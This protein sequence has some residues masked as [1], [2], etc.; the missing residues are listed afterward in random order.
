MSQRFRSAE[1]IISELMNIILRS[2]SELSLKPSLIYSES[3]KSALIIF[4]INN[5][6]SEHLNFE[7]QFIFLY[8]HFFL[9]IEWV[10]LT[11]S[12]RKLWLFVNQIKVLNV[13]YYIEKKIYILKFWIETIIKWS[14]SQNVKEIQSFLETVEIIRQWIKN[15]TEITQSLNKLTENVLWR[16]IQS[17]QLF[18][19]ILKIKCIT[20]I[21]MHEIDWSLDIH[22]YTDMSEFV[23]ELLITQF[24]IVDD[25]AKSVKV[26]I[27]YNT[28]T[29]SV[30]ERKYI[31]YKQKLCAIIKFI[32]K[33]HYLLWNL[34][35]QVIVHTDYKLLMHFLKLN[36]YNRIYSHWAAKLRKLNI[37]LIH[38][39]EKWNIVTDK[40]SQIIFFQKDCIE[41]ETV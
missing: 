35:Q 37:K 39:K 27:V 31:I 15:F 8:N 22:I 3:D 41:N 4:Y 36:L 6:F 18:F 7:I 12:F 28:F 16:W 26:F 34:N 30:T 29:F 21:F 19:K 32:S 23:S 2:I 40:L 24:Q 9:C 20:W 13:L 10:R 38:I 5:L 14:E 25:T 33:F 1:F 17:E 11:L